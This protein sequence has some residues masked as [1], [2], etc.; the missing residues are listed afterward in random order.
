MTSKIQAILRG[1]L[2]MEAEIGDIP[3][4]GIKESIVAI[5]QAQRHPERSV[6]SKMWKNNANLHP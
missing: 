6:A 5:L 3:R 2:A 1:L 4:N